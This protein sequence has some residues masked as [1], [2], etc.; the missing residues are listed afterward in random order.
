MEGGPCPPGDRGGG[1]GVAAAGGRGCG[2]PIPLPLQGLGGPSGVMAPEPRHRVS[3]GVNSVTWL[4]TLQG[5]PWGRWPVWDGQEG[6]LG[7][8]RAPAVSSPTRLRGPGLQEMACD[9]LNL[10]F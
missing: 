10:R 8:F 9:R 2:V 6:P 1:S 5:M 3:H 7:W 4:L